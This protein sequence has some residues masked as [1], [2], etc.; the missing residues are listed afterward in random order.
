MGAGAAVAGRRGPTPAAHLRRAR[1]RL[2]AVRVPRAGD[3]PLRR[4]RGVHRVHARRRRVRWVVRAHAGAELRRP[5][6]VGRARGAARRGPAARARA[7]AEPPRR[8][9]H[10]R[11]AARRARGH[12]AAAPGPLVVPD[13][14]ARRDAPRRRDGR[15]GLRRAPQ[16]ERQLPGLAGVGRGPREHD[17]ALHEPKVPEP[18]RVAALGRV[19]REALP[20]LQRQRAARAPRPLGQRLRACRRQRHR[21]RAHGEP[22]HQDARALAQPHR[23]RGRGRAR[24]GARGE[25]DA[26]RARARRQRDRDCR[27]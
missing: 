14:G 21:E 26:R 8:R 13:R 2:G 18:R 12:A 7:A 19:R 10:H 25:H 17:I 4:G 22:L 24:R 3:A 20:D 23:R 5:G 15:R 16:P 11:A 27:P 1:R 6:G 9:G